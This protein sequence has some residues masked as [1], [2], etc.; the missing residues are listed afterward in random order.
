MTER[1]AYLHAGTHKTGTSAIQT[2]MAMNEPALAESGIVWPRTGRATRWGSVHTGHHN[3]AWEFQAS[4]A[5]IPGEGTFAQACDEIAATLPAR[6]VFSSEEFYPLHDQPD[7]LIRMRAALNGLGYAL[8]AIIY[9][10]AQDEMLQALFSQIAKDWAF[11][12]FE[13]TLTTVLEKGAFPFAGTTRHY[14]L[15]YGRALDAFAHVLGNEH[16]IVRPYLRRRPHE[17]LYEFLSLVGGAQI[18]RPLLLE[19]CP[20]L[21]M[22]GAPAGTQVPQEVLYE[23]RFINQSPEFIGLIEALHRTVLQHNAAAADPQTFVRDL[24]PASDYPLLQRP[25]DVMTDQE[26]LAVARRFAQDNR[27]VT[28]R[29][30][31]GPPLLHESDLRPRTAL[32]NTAARTQRLVLD[33]AMRSWKAPSGASP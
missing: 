1:V 10:R 2:F 27:D 3:L 5:F 28:A 30:G 32:E 9:L 6:I 16:V 33:A 7:T 21:R 20:T 26:R 24:V 19:P 11:A 31:A 22:T 25:F 13:A 17:L 4:Q 15:T 12:D 18:P 14:E 29:Y 8:V 23:R